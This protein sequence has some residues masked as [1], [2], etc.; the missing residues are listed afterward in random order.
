[1]FCLDETTVPIPG[2]I[3]EFEV[4]IKV[5]E[6]TSPQLTFTTDVAHDYSGEETLQISVDVWEMDLGVTLEASPKIASNGD[7]VCF[8]VSA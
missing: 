2:G 6:V 7:E 8:E 3:F 1:M 4:V 5:L